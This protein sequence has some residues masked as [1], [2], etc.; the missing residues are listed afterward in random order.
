MTTTCFALTPLPN[1]GHVRPLKLRN[2][3]RFL[4][5][6][7]FDQDEQLIGIISEVGHLPLLLLQLTS[8]G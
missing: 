2:P 7:V 1:A 6:E 3:K 8:A 5:W 4:D